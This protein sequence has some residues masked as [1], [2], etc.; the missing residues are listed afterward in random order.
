MKLSVVSNLLSYMR[1][2]NSIL[3]EFYLFNLF[4]L[5]L[6]LWTL[7]L[8]LKSSL[9]FGDVSLWLTAVLIRSYN[10]VHCCLM[11]SILL[12]FSAMF[13]SGVIIIDKVDVWFNSE[14]S[15]FTE[16]DAKLCADNNE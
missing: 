10:T 2:K 11:K 16:F 14:F 15:N 13:K 6:S 7:V 1:L 5:S 12:K 4:S 3:L 9:L 8:W